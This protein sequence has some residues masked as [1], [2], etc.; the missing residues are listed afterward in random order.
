MQSIEKLEKLSDE[1]VQGQYSLGIVTKSDVGF[2]ELVKI[3]REKGMLQSNVE[4]IW[5]MEKDIRSGIK[6]G[7]MPITPQKSR[8]LI[9]VEGENKRVFLEEQFDPT[10]TTRDLRDAVEDIT[11]KHL[12][13]WMLAVIALW[14]LMNSYYLVFV[15]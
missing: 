1:Q 8:S 13:Y 14:L 7:S 2:Q 9:L 15:Y 5:L 10:R 4:G 12:A 11:R 3:L 6:V